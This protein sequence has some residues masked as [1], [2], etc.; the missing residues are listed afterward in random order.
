MKIR[1]RRWVWRGKVSTAWVLDCRV[2]GKRIRKHFPTRQEAEAYWLRVRRDGVDGGPSSDIMLSDLVEVYEQ[3]KPWR[4]ESYRERS[5]RALRNVPFLDRRVSQMSPRLIEEYRD[6]RLKSASAAT[7]R[8]ELASLSDCLKWAVKLGHLRKNPAAEVERPSLP[9]KQDD[10]QPFIT[11]EDFYE[12]L[13]PVAGRDGPMWEFMAWT[14][15][16]ITEVLQLSWP[17]VDFPQ[18]YV[19]VRR[20]KGRKQRLVPLLEPAVRALKAVPRHVSNQRIFWYASDR[21]ACLRRLQRQLKKAGL[22]S[23]RLHDLRHTFGAWAAM[24][25]VDLQVLAEAMGHTSTT[26]TKKYAHLSPAYKRREL[27]KMVGTREAQRIY[28]AAKSRRLHRS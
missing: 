4:T 13:L 20:G 21:H 26:V 1:K 8:Q 18:S 6:Q 27:E 11:Q 24:A 2:D 10:P 12:K 25:G 17:D 14:G 23:F 9:V 16:R 7:V 19:V 15:L 22:L 5:L 3:K 28:N